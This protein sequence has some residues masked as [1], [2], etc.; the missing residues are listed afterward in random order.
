MSN[1]L[2]PWISIDTQMSQLQR[3]GMLIDEEEARIWL[4]AVG[5]YRLSG[6]W[7]PYVLNGAL[8]QTDGEARF[9]CGTEFHEVVRLYEFDRKLRELALSAVE[10]IEVGFRSQLSYEL[11]WN[12]PEGHLNKSNYCSEEDH[13]AINDLVCKRIDR[14][15]SSNDPIA[16]HHEEKY[17]GR[18]PIWA[19]TEFFDFSDISRLYAAMVPEKKFAIADHFGFSPAPDGY[20]SGVR[21]KLQGWLHNLTVVRNT[22]AHHSRLWNRPFKP[23]SGK[24]VR[25]LTGLNSLPKSNTRAF[26][27]L[28]IMAF[29]L[30]TVSPGST[31]TAKVRNLVE[32]D[33]SQ[34]SMRS[35]AEM[36]FPI[37]WQ[38]N[39]IFAPC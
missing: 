27:S 23:T 2:K 25:L 28:S 7:R 1:P 15:R 3:R 35:L 18:Y 26:G 4:N 37:D 11:G 33:F 39:S 30:Q 8:Q 38:K 36:E 14:A 10:R 31:W 21:G 29:L 20:N 32:T 34:I 13:R 12:N 17:S 24:Q 9:A 5:Y 6:Y 16:I 22:A 19:V